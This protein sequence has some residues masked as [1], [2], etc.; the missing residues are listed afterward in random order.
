MSFWFTFTVLR[1]FFR[2]FAR[3]MLCGLRSPARPAPRRCPI[4]AIEPCASPRVRL[5][6]QQLPAARGAAARNRR[7]PSSAGVKILGLRRDAPRV[8]RRRA[9]RRPI[10]APARAARRTRRP[11][12]DGD[13][14][15]AVH[16][17]HARV[18]GARRG[19]ARRRVLAAEHRAPPA[20]RRE[21]RPSG[22]RA[23][24]PVAV[25][26]G[27]RLRPPDP[28]PRH[29]CAPLAHAAARRLPAQLPA[30]RPRRRRG[31]QRLDRRLAARAPR[32]DPDPAPFTKRIVSISNYIYLNTSASP[33]SASPPPPSGRPAPAQPPP[34]PASSW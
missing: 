9:R 19:R 21:R 34:P 7:R 5:L 22:L 6:R 23:A 11:R 14:L 33:S 12:N 13:G 27:R 18:G 8:G 29:L 30:R 24:A 1:V 17:A 15:R 20:L 32:L 31:R 26:A 2:G 3:A 16:C 25:R 4:A 28:L 10:R